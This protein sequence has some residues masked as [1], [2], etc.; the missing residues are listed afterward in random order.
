MA[1][2]FPMNSNASSTSLSST[3][4]SVDGQSIFSSESPPAHTT[5]PTSES[6]HSK[7]SSMTYTD[8]DWAKEVRWLVQPIPRTKPRA[9]PKSFLSSPASLSVP[10]RLKPPAPRIAHMSK[11]MSRATPSIMTVLEED[12]DLAVTLRPTSRV[13]I[14]GPPNLQRRRSRSLENMGPQ[15]TSIP[16]NG[17]PGYTSLTLPRAPPPPFQPI[18]SRGSHKVTMVGG[19]DGRID[20]TISGVAQ[21]TMLRYVCRIFA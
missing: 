2:P 17:T 12:E 21:T 6:G 18:S 4:A 20:L 11:S 10:P 9:S 7:R 3:T 13:L 8:E 5:P 15:E 19:G 14:N 16:S 1:I